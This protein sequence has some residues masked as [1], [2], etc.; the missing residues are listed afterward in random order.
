MPR[1]CAV[2]GRRFP[3]GRGSTDPAFRPPAPLQQGRRSSTSIV[4]S[5]CTRTSRPEGAGRHG[6]A[7]VSQ[8][9]A[10]LKG[11]Q[12]FHLEVAVAPALA[13]KSAENAAMIAPQI[14]DDRRPAATGCSRTSASGCRR[15]DPAARAPRWISAGPNC[16]ATSPRLLN[17]GSYG[18]RASGSAS[19]P[20]PA[21]C[22]P[23]ARSSTSPETWRSASGM[24]ME[25]L[26]ATGCRP[27]SSSSMAAS[28]RHAGNPANPMLNM[29][30]NTL[31]YGAC[32][33]QMMQAFGGYGA[34]VEDN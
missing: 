28:A 16:R 11:R 30:P 4:R 2:A 17:A 21:S 22:T 10:A 32:Y 24:E 1:A 13:K 33:D 14:S 23:T 27:R 20:P 29:R 6:K 5:R 34:C 3:D 31:I 25:T 18:T 8:L 15:D 9:N 19:W 26:C 12:W 7:I